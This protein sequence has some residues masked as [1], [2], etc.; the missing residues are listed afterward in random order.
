MKQ[1]KL[2]SEIP[3]PTQRFGLPSDGGK[4]GIRYNL[5]SIMR[6]CHL[7]FTNK[8]SNWQILS[9][10]FPGHE[11]KSQSNQHVLSLYKIVLVVGN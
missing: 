5:I 11:L 7:T 1:T 2:T 9:V 8:A 4:Q 10:F 6:C 3:F